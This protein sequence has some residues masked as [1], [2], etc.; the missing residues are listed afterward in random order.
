EL[1]ELAGGEPLGA[2]L[3]LDDV[4]P[5]PLDG[6]GEEALHPDGV[7]ADEAGV[8]G[9][10]LHFGFL[11]DEVLRAFSIASSAR[12][13]ASRA[14]RREF[15]NSRVSRIHWVSSSNGRG[16][17]ARK[18]SRPS[19]RRRTRPARSRSLMCLETELS[20]MSNGAATSVTRAS[21]EA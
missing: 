17:S 12:S 20:E 4:G 6:T 14:S 7:L 5:H 19:T 8:E 1:A 2:L 18:W 3:A 11:L 21:P 9:L 10:G 16:S 13:A 15:Q